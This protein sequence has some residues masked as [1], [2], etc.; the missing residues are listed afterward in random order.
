MEDNIKI[1]VYKIVLLGDNYSGT[2]C[3]IRRY[4]YNEYDPNKYSHNTQF[5]EK[6]IISENGNKLSIQFWDIFNQQ[7]YYSFN[8]IYI[9]NSHGII[10]T[11]DIT[12]RASFENAI[13][14]LNR[15]KEDFKEILVFAL[16][17]LK[18]DSF[19]G[20]VRV[21]E[22]RK[23]AQDNDM[24]FY[25]TSAKKNIEVENCFN[26]IINEIIRKEEI[27][28]E[29]KNLINLNNIK[30]ERSSKKGCLK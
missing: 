27:E 29:N 13:Q 19:Y 25:L 20:E 30:R 1:K 4:I 17:G 16:V 11:Y 5:F 10:F 12:N 3:L 22:A 8:R 26:G 2:T 21:L 28:N 15:I 18:S 23:F 24:L 7:R 6:K 9:N 14:R